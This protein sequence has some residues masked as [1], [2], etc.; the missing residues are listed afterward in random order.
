MLSPMP[1]D[2]PVI[3][4]VLPS[5]RLPIAEAIEYSDRTLRN[6]GRDGILA[7]VP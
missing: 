7:L 6:R 4:I 3:R 5:R 1:D 2:A